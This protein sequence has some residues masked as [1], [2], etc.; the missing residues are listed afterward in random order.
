MIPN[1][2]LFVSIF[3]GLAAIV[4]LVLFYLAVKKSKNSST[5]NKAVYVLL[6]MIL[7]LIVQAILT[8]KNVYSTNTDVFPPKIILLG[9]LPAAIIILGLFVTAAGRK[10]IDG[11]PLQLLTYLNVVRI[12]VELTLFWLFLNRAVPE[13]M[14]FEGH[15]FDIL[16]GISAPFVAY[17]GF[18]KKVLSQNLILIWNFVCL[19][20]L[21]NIVVLALLSAQTPI[22]Q[23]GFDQPN[24]AIVFFPF[25]WLPTFIVPVVLFGHLASIRQLL[26]QKFE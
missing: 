3:F 10:F 17:F 2:P 24:V 14:T 25:S 21:I 12:P 11:L 23:F 20:L 5:Q 6:G 22:Q 1:L 13:L 16:A 18:T 7:W 9:V 4:T 15:N 8:L 19:A 26:K